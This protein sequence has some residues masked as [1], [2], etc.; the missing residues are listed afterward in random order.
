MKFVFLNQ[1]FF[2]QPVSEISFHKDATYQG[3]GMGTRKISKEN[4]DPSENNK[5]EV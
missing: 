3:R 1:L 2:F 5:S 4:E